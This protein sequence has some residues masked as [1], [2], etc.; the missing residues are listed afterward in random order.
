LTLGTAFFIL[1]AVKECLQKVYQTQRD[2]SLKK[3]SLIPLVGII[4]FTVSGRAFGLE[5]L[6]SSTGPGL[7]LLLLI[8]TRLLWS[9]PV[10]LMVSEE[11][12]AWLWGLDY[13][14]DMD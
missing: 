9:L 2:F 8:A 6:V 11:N 12:E 10:A 4:Y 7:T 3:I 1:Q 13:S 14:P 5:E